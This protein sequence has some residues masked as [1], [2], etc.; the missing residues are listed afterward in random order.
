MRGRV[1]SRNLCAARRE[2][3]TFLISKLKASS[4]NCS[5]AQSQPFNLLGPTGFGQFMATQ[6]LSLSFEFLGLLVASE[7][8]CH[9]HEHCVSHVFRQCSCLRQ[10]TR[11]AQN[12]S[13][14]F[15][16]AL[17]DQCLQLPIGRG[18]PQIAFWPA[19]LFWALSGS[20]ALPKIEEP[21][22]TP[23][24]LERAKATR[25]EVRTRSR[26]EK[27][28]TPEPQ[29]EGGPFDPIRLKQA[30]KCPCP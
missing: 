27:N 12:D 15:G 25:Q 16:R 22:Q 26:M 30:Q 11:L 17:A 28:N 21:G 9:A 4:Q 7:T 3:P 10:A 24:G 29:K 14:S 1:D 5:L 8:I 18:R 6:T 19:V 20:L 2:S 13:R 23:K